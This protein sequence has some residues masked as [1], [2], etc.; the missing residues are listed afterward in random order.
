M[1]PKKYCNGLVQNGRVQAEIDKPLIETP[2]PDQN[3]R[4]RL[5]WSDKNAEF[6]T[7]APFVSKVAKSSAKMITHLLKGRDARLLK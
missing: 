2:N 4:A 6:R 1:C 3:G 7:V 5:I